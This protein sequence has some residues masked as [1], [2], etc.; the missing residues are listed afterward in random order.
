ML[1]YLAQAVPG[2]PASLGWAAVAIVT[3]AAICYKF[4]AIPER[5]R[6]NNNEGEVKRVNAVL[7]EQV[8]PALVS[9]NDIQARTQALLVEL[10]RR[11]GNGIP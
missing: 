7:I 10:Q 2:D 11:S 1:L 3:G 5:E 6:A 4:V 9:A 8:V